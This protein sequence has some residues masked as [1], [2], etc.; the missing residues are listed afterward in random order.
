MSSTEI[1]QTNGVP[2]QASAA[3]ETKQPVGRKVRS[4]VNFL[5]LDPREQLERWCQPERFA[6]SFLQDG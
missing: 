2:P 1:N 5:T 6:R 4:N 3:A